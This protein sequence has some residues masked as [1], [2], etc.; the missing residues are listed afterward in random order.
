M[1]ELV[2]ASGNKGKL[3]EIKSIIEDLGFDFLGEDK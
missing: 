1:K 2:V 3:E